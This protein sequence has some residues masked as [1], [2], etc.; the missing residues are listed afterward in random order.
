VA[1]TS[2]L[3]RGSAS[4]SNSAVTALGA[5]VAAIEAADEARQHGLDI[6]RDAGG[7]FGQHGRR[8]GVRPAVAL[9]EG[10]GAGDEQQLADL[11]RMAGGDGQRHLGAER[12]AAERVPG[13]QAGGDGVDRGIEIGDQRFCRSRAG[14]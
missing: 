4:C 9:D 6:G 7:E 2:P 12:P 10:G 13:L 11:V 5:G 8:H 14:R 3:G 1:S